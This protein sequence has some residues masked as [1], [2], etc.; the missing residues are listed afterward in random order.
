MTVPQTGEKIE[1][2]M[3]I[4]DVFRAF[5]GKKDELTAIMTAAGLH[6]VG[7]GASFNE[8][9]EQGMIVHGMD[10][11]SISRVVGELN[12]VVEGET[13]VPLVRLT[14]NPISITPRALGKL[15]QIMQDENMSGH[16]LRVAVA[17]GGCAGN[18][19]VLDFEDKASTDD[20][21]FEQDGLRVFVDPGSGR[22]LIGTEID[23]VETL[24]EQ[25][26]KFNNPNAQDACGCGSSFS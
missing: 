10:G 7:C 17:A 19:Y 3:T 22:Q 9:L 11:E 25:G 2:G 5:P 14:R 24:T 15:K 20:F 13:P 16:G 8:T 1:K 12:S 23:Y 21:V 6:C 4:A 26:F 18:T